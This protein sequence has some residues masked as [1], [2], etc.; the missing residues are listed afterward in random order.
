MPT[1]ATQLP[2]REASAVSATASVTAPWPPTVM[3]VPRRMLPSGSSADR[4]SST[5]SRRSWA[6]PADTATSATSAGRADASAD[7]VDGP[8]S[9]IPTIYKRMFASASGT[10]PGEA[11]S[12]QRSR[13]R[14]RKAAIWDRLTGLWGQ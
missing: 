13:A 2:R 12:A 8:L 3:A 6:A 14:A 5:G 9:A 1:A 11:Q 4:P 10:S 7:A